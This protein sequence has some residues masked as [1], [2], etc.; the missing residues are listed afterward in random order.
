MNY[1]H[2]WGCP[3]EDKMFNP[4]IRKLESKMVSYHLFGYPER[5]K[6]YC[7]YCSNKHTKFVK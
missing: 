1:F 2:M 5:S 6:G 7:F 4:N 3:M